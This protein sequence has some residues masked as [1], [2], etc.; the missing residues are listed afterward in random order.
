MDGVVMCR[1]YGG[2][3]KGKYRYFPCMGNTRLMDR[4]ILERLIKEAFDKMKGLKIA[5]LSKFG[6]Q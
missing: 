1:N 2:L 5:P 6:T 3:I 4:D